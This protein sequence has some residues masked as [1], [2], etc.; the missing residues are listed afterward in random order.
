MI[1]SCW[2]L[3]LK[4]RSALSRVSPSWMWT[5]AKL[6]SP[7]FYSRTCMRLQTYL[8]GMR[9]AHRLSGYQFLAFH[10]VKDQVSESHTNRNEAQ[11]SE[12][13]RKSLFFARRVEQDSQLLRRG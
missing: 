12:A 1:S 9:Y 3:R 13:D 6:D 11:E 5:S 10:P 2:T 4:R 7:A 8:R